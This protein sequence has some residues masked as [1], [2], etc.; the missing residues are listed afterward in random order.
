LRR[1]LV[2]QQN[3][4]LFGSTSL[5]SKLRIYSLQKYFDIKFTLT[6]SIILQTQIMQFERRALHKKK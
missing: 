1:T 2:L 5:Y 6:K 4:Q 3:L